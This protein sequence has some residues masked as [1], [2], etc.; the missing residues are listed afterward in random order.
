MKWLLPSCLAV[1]ATVSAVCAPVA[2]AATPVTV[3]FGT[4]WDGPG[5]DLQSVVDASL[6]APGLINV[7]TDFIGAHAG[8]LDPWFWVGSSFPTLLITEV[9]SNA[10]TSDLG[11][12]S[13]DFSHPLIDGV[14]DGLVF[15]G[16]QGTG[17]SVLVTFPSGTTRFGFYLDTHTIVQPPTGVENQVFFTNRFHNDIGPSGM[18][19]LH[20]PLDGD[21]QALVFDVSQWKGTNTWLVC[22][23]DRDSGQAIAPCCDGTDNDFNDMVFQITADGATPTQKTSFGAVK[24]GGR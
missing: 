7:Q 15:S 6:G 14:Q 23:E 24:A 2:Q 1:L 16:S 5:Q 4:T 17:S 22:F 11:W 12:Y 21:V 19:S 3:A 10:N 18:G 20:A 8:D 13:E 9:A